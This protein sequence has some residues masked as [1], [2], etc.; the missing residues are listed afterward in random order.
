MLDKI[1]IP[2]CMGVK[3]LLLIDMLGVSVG[4]YFC[5]EMHAY[6]QFIN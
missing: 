5:P 4:V 6:Q 3:K 2:L 1:S